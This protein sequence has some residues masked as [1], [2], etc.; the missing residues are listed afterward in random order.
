MK[1]RPVTGVRNAIPTF[2]IPSLNSMQTT[3]RDVKITKPLETHLSNVNLKVF[4][5]P[6][7]STQTDIPTPPKHT[8]LNASKSH[9]LQHTATYRQHSTHTT[10]LTQHTY[11]HTYTTSKPG[12]SQ[13]VCRI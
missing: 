10:I 9:P 3:L 5:H 12:P 8:Q 7:S 4:I 1:F 6:H 2:P 13:T 11:N